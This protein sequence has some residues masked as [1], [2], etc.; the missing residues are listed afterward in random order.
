MT[1]NEFTSELTRLEGLKKSLTVA[2]VK[3]VIRLANMMLDG[4]VYKL[5][6][7]SRKV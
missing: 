6:K 1:I 3:E 5:I 2:D 7:K 4:E